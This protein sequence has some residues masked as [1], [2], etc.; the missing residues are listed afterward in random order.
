MYNEITN[1]RALTIFSSQSLSQNHPKGS[2]GRM[3]EDISLRGFTIMPK[4]AKYSLEGLRSEMDNLYAEEIHQ[5]GIQNLQKIND[6]GVVRNPFYKSQLV[7]NLIFQDELLGLL[8]KIFGNQ[9]IMHVN[10][11]VVSDPNFEHPASVWHREPPYNKFIAQSPMSI[12]V[13]HLPDGSNE[14]NAGL[15]LLPGSHKWESFPSDDYVL[16][17][18][19][20]PIV[21]P[22]GI[23]VFDSSLLHRGGFKS[24][25]KRRSMVTIYT[26]P[27]IKQ[28]VDIASV[29]SSKFFSFLDEHPLAARI[30]GVDTMISGDDESYRNK[31]ILME[32]KI[33]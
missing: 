14:E 17:N 13:V 19:I 8:D 4:E 1:E 21:E 5:W 32:R 16:N 25:E 23:L 7:R 2:L 29:V 15:V 24:Q 31:K 18:Q 11:F 9:F 6:L 33:L 3:Y 12:T 20:V 26:S 22:G 28:Q 27:I 10:R 30:Y